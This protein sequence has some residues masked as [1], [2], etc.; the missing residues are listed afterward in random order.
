MSRQTQAAL[1]GGVIVAALIT[2][3]FG[4][5]SP[6]S[7]DIAPAAT[8]ESVSGNRV[9]EKTSAAR[10]TASPASV[11]VASNNA[12]AAFHTLQICALRLRRARNHELSFG[13]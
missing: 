5:R 6:T 12:A 2:M 1:I 7:T 9:S 4:V 13:L 8:S 10:V 3:Y 11:A